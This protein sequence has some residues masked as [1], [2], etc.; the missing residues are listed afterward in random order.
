MQTASAN[1]EHL[2]DE[3]KSFVPISVLIVD[4]EPE[5]AEELSEALAEYGFDCFVAGS[6]DEAQDLMRENDDITA[7]VTDFHLR[8]SLPPLCDGLK[9]VEFLRAAHPERQLDCVVVSGDRDVLAECTVHGAEKF[10]SKPI[11]P[12]SLNSMLTGVAPEREPDNEGPVSLVL[13]HRL[14]ESQSKAIESLTEALADQEKGNR[15]ATSRMDRLVLAARVAGNRTKLGRKDEVDTLI[16]YI[17]GQGA[18][19]S[20]LL[21]GTGR[22][23]P[24]QDNQ[25]QDT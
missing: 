21:T 10:L 14:V 7:V 2:N 13:L 8:G 12:E 20:R 6:A 5:A 16:G 25:G 18:E 17:E 24:P 4:D 23:P 19:V 22:R 3:A 1:F 9:L 11:A 15:E